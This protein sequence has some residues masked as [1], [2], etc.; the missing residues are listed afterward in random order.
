MNV[1]FSQCSETADLCG[2]GCQTVVTEV[3]NRRAR[4]G[5]VQPSTVNVQ[6]CQCSETADLCGKGFQTVG[7]EAS[8]RR[9]SINAFQKSAFRA[10]VAHARS[11]FCAHIFRGERKFLSKKETTKVPKSSLA[12]Q[13]SGHKTRISAMCG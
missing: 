8:N 12:G 10:R 2:K 7:I 6:A 5:S 1:Q 3:S 13:P 9:A 4:M 11:H